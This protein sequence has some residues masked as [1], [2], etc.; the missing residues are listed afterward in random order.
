MVVSAI[1][2]RPCVAGGGIRALHWNMLSWLE[3]DCFRELRGLRLYVSDGLGGLLMV[4]VC[5]VLCVERLHGLWAVGLYVG[6][7]RCVDGLFIV[8]WV[9]ENWEWAGLGSENGWV[10]VLFS[11]EGV[12]GWE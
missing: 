11:G 6:W 7:L 3:L 8:D 4:V 12:L 5:W 10:S 9:V 2:L 1:R